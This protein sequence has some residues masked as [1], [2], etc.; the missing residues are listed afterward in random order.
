[1]LVV[2]LAASDF[3]MIQHQAVPLFVN[4]FMSRYWA[5]GE[6]ACELYGFLGGVFGLGSLWLIIFIGFHFHFFER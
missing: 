6:L 3:I 4:A 1:M 5:F 2:A